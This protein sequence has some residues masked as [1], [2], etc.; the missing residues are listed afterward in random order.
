[1]FQ[2]FFM[3]LPSICFICNKTTNTDLILSKTVIWDF[4][5]CGQFHVWLKTSCCCLSTSDVFSVHFSL[6]LDKN[7]VLWLAVWNKIIQF[8]ICFLCGWLRLASSKRAPTKAPGDA[9][10]ISLIISVDS[11]H[12][13]E[14][15]AAQVTSLWP[16]ISYLQVKTFPQAVCHLSALNHNNQ[17]QKWP[18]FKIW[19]L[20]NLIL[21]HSKQSRWFSSWIYW[22]NISVTIL[23]L[24]IITYW[25]KMAAIVFNPIWLKNKK[26]LA[27]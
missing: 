13:V 16:L 10:K 17:Q 1:M 9:L 7:V 22:S 19:Y 26:N 23:L 3:F 6:V 25:V 27:I 2:P 8:C 15:K 21:E 18:A 12:G 11:F 24:A 14:N 5:W 20:D 4:L